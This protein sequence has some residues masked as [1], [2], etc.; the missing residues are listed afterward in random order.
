MAKT[1]SKCKECGGM[2]SPK[3]DLCPHCGVKRNAGKNAL[4]GCLS[5]LFGIV[6]MLIFAWIAIEVLFGT[7][8]PAV[9]I[10]ELEDKCAAAAK[11]TP[12][13]MDRK[14]F[15][16]NCVAGGKAKLRADGVIK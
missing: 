7:K 8:D 16:K 12:S 4:K 2:V 13:N 15:Y 1:M 5:S 3:A 9:L 10:K 14:A 11:E 6:F